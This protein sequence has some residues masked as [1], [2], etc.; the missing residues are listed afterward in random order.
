MKK[1]YLGDSV[2]AVDDGFHV[3]L[4]TDNG[5]GPSNEIYLESN[6]I[7]NL[8]MFIEES[9]GLK[10]TVKRVAQDERDPKNYQSFS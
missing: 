10:I 7:I 8:I 6:V 5:L 1:T 3:V 2:Y 4:T 9:R